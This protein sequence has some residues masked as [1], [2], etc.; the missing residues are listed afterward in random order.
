MQQSKKISVANRTWF[1][2]QAEPGENYDVCANSTHQTLFFKR[3]NG[4]D[5]LVTPLGFGNFFSEKVPATW[6][7]LSTKALEAYAA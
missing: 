4:V 7:V 6:S 5:L 1:I 2:Y 3:L